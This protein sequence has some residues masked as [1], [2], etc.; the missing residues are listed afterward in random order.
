MELRGITGI[1]PAANRLESAVARSCEPY[2]ESNAD[3][4]FRGCPLLSGLSQHHPHRPSPVA[5]ARG[6]NPAMGLSMS[7]I[8]SASVTGGFSPGG[9]RDRR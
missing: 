1:I 5:I 7:M 9:L 4:C 2:P 6:L 3:W 8:S